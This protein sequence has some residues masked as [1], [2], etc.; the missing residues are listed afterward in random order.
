MY[1]IIYLKFVYVFLANAAPSL[2]VDPGSSKV[3]I[4][5]GE[6]TSVDL[7]YIDEGTVTN[8]VT[9]GGTAVTLSDP[10]SDGEFKANLQLNSISPIKVR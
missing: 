10:N 6:S 5:V 2:V 7:Q 4:L 8:K 1:K 9:S 3:H